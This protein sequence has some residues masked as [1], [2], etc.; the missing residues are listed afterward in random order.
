MSKESKSKSTTPTLSLTASGSTSSPK[1]SRSSKRNSSG[2]STSPKETS[3]QL[4][5]SSSAGVIVNLIVDGCSFPLSLDKLRYEKSY[6]SSLF[7]NFDDSN[8]NSHTI[9]SENCPLIM[10]PY[11]WQY[12]CD[13]DNFKFNLSFDAA[14]Q[15]LNVADY[16]SLEGLK[17]KIT[18]K[19]PS[20]DWF[21]HNTWIKIGQ[22]YNLTSGS[23]NKQLNHY[24]CFGTSGNMHMIELDLKSRIYDVVKSYSC[25]YDL[26]K[27]IITLVECAQPFR[28]NNEG[29]GADAPITGARVS[30]NASRRIKAARD[31]D[32]S[33]VFLAPSGKICF[34]QMKSNA[35]Y[36]LSN[37]ELTDFFGEANMK[38]NM[39][40]IVAKESIILSELL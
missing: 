39:A 1:S 33:Y 34:E 14:N 19:Y 26:N 10:F 32:I 22:I 24:V 16:F 11:V 36:Y 20:I 6:F 9:E 38:I 35:L 5:P 3:P 28:V 30:P 31:V 40:D 17:S 25:S 21:K 27:N 7:G 4:S 2:G 37:R 8:A 13:P 18:S 15:L 12:L 23:Q 29:E